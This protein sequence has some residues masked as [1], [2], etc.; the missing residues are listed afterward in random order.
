MSLYDRFGFAGSLISAFYS[1]ATLCARIK[2]DIICCR[3]LQ[4]DL[5]PLPL[6]IR[7]EVVWAPSRVCSLIARQ[8]GMTLERQVVVL[9]SEH[10]FLN[11]VEWRCRDKSQFMVVFCSLAHPIH[12]DCAILG[13]R[14]FFVHSTRRVQG[15]L[16]HL[17]CELPAAPDPPRHSINLLIC[18][19]HNVNFDSTIRLAES[20]E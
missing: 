17:S 9:L 3:S 2:Y 16:C 19:I 13:L 5:F 10:I 12:V 4:A 1:S 20:I 6:N 18:R 8:T 11:A 14:W 7:V 15:A